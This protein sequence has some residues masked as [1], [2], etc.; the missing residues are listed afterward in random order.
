MPRH[1]ERCNYVVNQTAKFCTNCGSPLLDPLAVA[2]TV[3]PVRATAS[4]QAARP[5]PPRDLRPPSQQPIDTALSSVPQG[6]KVAAGGAAIALVGCFLPLVSGIGENTSVIPNLVNQVPQALV[7]PLSAIAIVIIAWTAHTAQAERK[8]LLHGGIIAVSSPWAVFLLLGVLAAN[9][10]SSSLGPFTFGAG[11]GI[12]VI[13]L[14]AGFS[15]SLVGG[16][17]SLLETVRSLEGR[18]QKGG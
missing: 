13:M 17:M 2:A 14:V 10:A 5:L 12:G 3:S 1:C 6:A 16:F 15:A 11:I 4:N 9:K 8:S 7:V 18:G